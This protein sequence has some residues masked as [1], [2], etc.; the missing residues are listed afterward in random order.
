MKLFFEKMIDINQ[1]DTVILFGNL[2]C[3]M[4]GKEKHLGSASLYSS[5]LVGLDLSYVDKN[6]FKALFTIGIGIKRYTGVQTQMLF[7]S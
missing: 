2:D 6:I 1:L 7:L 4:S 3:L 5:S